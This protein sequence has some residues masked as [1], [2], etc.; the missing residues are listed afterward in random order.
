MPVLPPKVKL[1]CKVKTCNERAI[2]HGLCNAHSHRL[3]VC[4]DVQAEVPIQR[5]RR[6][7]TEPC[8]I[9]GCGRPYSA[10]GLCKQHYME[11]RTVALEC[12]PCVIPECD[13]PRNTTTGYC[14]RHYQRFL[15]H[16]DPTAGGPLRCRR[17]TG[18][19][20]AYDEER[21]AA[22]AKMSQVGGEIKEYVLILRS[23]PCVYCGAPSKHIDHIVP[24][25]DGGPTEW[26]NLAPACL[27]CNVR[28][29][30][31]SLLTFLLV[32]QNEAA[33]AAA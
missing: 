6:G 12:E 1:S 7:V 8:S 20:W 4:G 21:R 18:D 31:R 13:R 17:G 10:K 9:E 32:R 27:R 2:R 22:G 5:K 23:D 25:A 14:A 29:S 19:R 26:D 15:K 28:K 16:G 33:S 11:A 3:R 24:F 30:R